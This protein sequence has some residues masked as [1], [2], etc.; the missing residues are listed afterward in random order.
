ME[1]LALIAA[2]E[3][4]L[5]SVWFQETFPRGGRSDAPGCAVDACQM[6]VG[7]GRVEGK[8]T[9]PSFLPY[10]GRV[11]VAE[12]K[13]TFPVQTQPTRREASA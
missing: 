1:C 12:A 8:D 9:I 13:G 3:S 4:T 7:R 5:S 10:P 6:S 11:G 2:Q